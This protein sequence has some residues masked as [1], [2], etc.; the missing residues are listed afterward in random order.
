MRNEIKFNCPNCN[1]KYRYDGLEE[2]YTMGSS[3]TTLCS[4]IHRLTINLQI[5]VYGVCGDGNYK[6]RI[7]CKSVV[8]EGNED[9]R[10]QRLMD[11]YKYVRD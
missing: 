10:M 2:Y 1:Q 4:C 8:D 11:R 7:V 5:E 9:I 3:I 6:K